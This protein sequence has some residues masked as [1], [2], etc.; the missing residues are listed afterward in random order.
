MYDASRNLA[1]LLRGGSRARPAS[2]AAEP[3]QK[4]AFDKTSDALKAFAAD[5]EAFV[6][7]RS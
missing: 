4:A 3:P 5:W 6:K 1:E 2:G 7:G